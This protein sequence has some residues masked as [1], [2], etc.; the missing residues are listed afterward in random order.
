[1]NGFGGHIVVEGFDECQKQ[2]HNHYSGK[3]I[4]W[5]N[6][7]GIFL[8]RRILFWN[9]I[10]SN[11]NNKCQKGTIL[12]FYYTYFDFNQLIDSMFALIFSHVF[13]IGVQ[14]S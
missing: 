13:I 6:Q 4:K 11:Y 8:E 10:V 2:I 12:S 1:M 14:T 5:T 3:H 9:F 7:I